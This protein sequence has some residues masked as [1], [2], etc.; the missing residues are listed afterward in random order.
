MK[1][2]RFIDIKW[3]ISANLN[4]RVVRVLEQ[5]TDFEEVF[6]EMTK[7]KMKP[8]NYKLWT[9]LFHFKT[10]SPV[11]KSCHVAVMQNIKGFRLA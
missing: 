10:P 4:L 2:S 5:Y 9:D 6:R 7:N 11:L 3:K 8:N 1:H